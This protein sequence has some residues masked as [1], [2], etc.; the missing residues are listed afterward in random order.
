MNGA[1]L[2]GI[3]FCITHDYHWRCL[4]SVLV[5]KAAAVSLYGEQ[6]MMD[7]L[8]ST[9]FDDPAAWQ[10]FASGKAQGILM[11]S[12]EKH[13]L[14]LEYDFHGG[15]GFVVIRRTVSLDLPQTF[16]FRFFCRGD[17]PRNHFEVKVADPGGTNVWR[18]LKQ[19][20]CLPKDWDALEFTERE[21]PFAWGPAGGGAPTDVGAIEFVSAAGPG[22][23]GWIELAMPALADET[24]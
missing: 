20:F 11:E 5:S 3:T 21:L 13:G 18:H 15:G 19:D 8:F 6:P 22:G 1:S 16:R 12:H 9:L 24:P 14:R 17:G 2:L 7:T 10:V 23:A 4:K